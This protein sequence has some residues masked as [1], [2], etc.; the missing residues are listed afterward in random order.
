LRIL[1]FTSLLLALISCKQEV[2]YQSELGI[3]SEGWSHEDSYDFN[4]TALDTT[5]VYE[6]QL[7]VRHNQEYRYEN[8]YLMVETVFPRQEPRQ[9]RINISLADKKGQWVGK[10]RSKD[11]RV[12]VYMLD[13]FR[14]PELGEYTF[15][16]NQH[17]REENLGGVQSLE[18]RIIEKNENL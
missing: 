11:C 10:C 6:M 9:E 5:T 15:I 4:L 13:G 7:L 8:L 3:N 1:L 12:M 16:F 2:F 18:L 17:T 14:F